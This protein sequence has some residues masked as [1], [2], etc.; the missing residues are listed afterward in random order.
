[1]I[2]DVAFLFREHLRELQCARSVFSRAFVKI[3]EYSIKIGKH[4]DANRVKECK[5]D[6][7]SLKYLHCEQ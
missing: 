1:M 5:F 2:F 3:R 4:C 6:D 7:F